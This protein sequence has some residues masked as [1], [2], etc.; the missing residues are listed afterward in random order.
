M[1]G[2]G[3]VTIGQPTLATPTNEKC[4]KIAALIISTSKPAIQGGAW[5]F[6]C[7][8]ILAKDPSISI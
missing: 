7:H 8:K 4:V 3:K 6:L 2:T 5:Q 1:S